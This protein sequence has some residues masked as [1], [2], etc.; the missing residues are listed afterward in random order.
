MT[1]ALRLRELWI[2]PVKSVAGVRLRSAEVVERGLAGDRRYMVVSPDGRFLTQ[3][4]Q[5]ALATLR[6]EPTPRGLS[7]RA[8]GGA[9]I[10]VD[11]ERGEPREVTVW[12][13]AVAARDLGAGPA[14]LLSEHLGV[15]A[16]LVYMP[17]STRRP[18]DREHA[19]E[20]DVVS[21]AD[22]FPF[23]LTSTASLAALDERL[24][25]PVDMRRF[26][27]NLVVE[28][29]APFAEDDWARIEIGPITFLGSKPC[30]RC[31]IVDVDPD[32]GV[33]DG[34][35]LP[36]LNR[37]RK[38]DRQVIFGVNLVHDGRGRLEEGMP[39]RVWTK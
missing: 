29:A 8:P 37:F 2:Y 14:R 25:E 16:R 4:E 23:L 24:E 20:D 3:R 11:P 21:F 13:D 7:L 38:V 12:G 32:R 39:V 26:R 5:P 1:D 15:E 33:R 9:R 31:A 35:V 34:R 19:R 17:G 28:G 22:G 30:S 6:A 10:E 36:E 18:A 27:P